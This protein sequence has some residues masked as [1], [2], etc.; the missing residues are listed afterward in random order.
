MRAAQR[1]LLCFGAALIGPLGNSPYPSLREPPAVRSV[2][3]G[4]F[5]P[6]TELPGAVALPNGAVT[7]RLHG[8]SHG[9]AKRRRSA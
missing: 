6:F 9:L 3:W 2:R 5:A 4:C 7:L 8:Q 1:R